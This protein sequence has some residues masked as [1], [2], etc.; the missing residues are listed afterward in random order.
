MKSLKI[1][2]GV[3]VL[4]DFYFRA[5]WH[6]RRL[7]FVLRGVARSGTVVQKLCLALLAALARIQESSCI[8]DV[9]WRNIRGLCTADWCTWKLPQITRDKRVSRAVI[10][11]AVSLCPDICVFQEAPRAAQHDSRTAQIST[12]V[13]CMTVR[14]SARHAPSSE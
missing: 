9:L 12:V 3:D 4:Q 10:W 1:R 2:L 13:F 11:L 7:R 5:P 8:S 14:Y 6:R